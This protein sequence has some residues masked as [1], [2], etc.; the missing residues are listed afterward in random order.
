M[1]VIG[2]D[3]G[4]HGGVAVID[5]EANG[6][7]VSTDTPLSN[8]TYDPQAMMELLLPEEGEEVVAF[9]E[10]QTGY[11]SDSKKATFSTGFGYGVW[12]TLLRLLGVPYKE[13]SPREWQSKMG[14][15]GNCYGDTK[16]AS[17]ELASAYFPGQDFEKKDGRSDAVLI[18]I[19][20]YKKH[21]SAFQIASTGE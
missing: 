11:R 18:G 6:L 2:I 4:K 12:L 13:I 21:Y 16:K 8:K 20:G 14:I 1:L 15:Y 19:Y 10:K 17:L 5:M 7:K 9:I 3:P